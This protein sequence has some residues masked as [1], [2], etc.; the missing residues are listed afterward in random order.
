MARVGPDDELQ[1]WLLDRLVGHGSA[2]DGHFREPNLLDTLRRDLQWLLTTG[3]LEQS[4][5]LRAY[6]N[7]S[8]SVLNYGW[9]SLCGRLLTDA[10][11]EKLQTQLTEAI[12]RFEPR[13]IP[14]TLRVL[15]NDEGAA[16]SNVCRFFIV[17][18]AWAY[19]APEPFRFETRF[20]LESGNVEIA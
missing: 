19:P 8:K 9:I 7:V 13:V 20:D 4:Q 12:L 10:E 2:Q 17:A 5:D 15:P 3:N 16:R 11:L 6:P 18:E 1:P 14:E